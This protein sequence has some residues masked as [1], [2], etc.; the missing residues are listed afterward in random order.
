MDVQTQTALIGAAVTVFVICLACGGAIA[1]LR[2]A[3]SIRGLANPPAEPGVWGLMAYATFVASF[4]GSVGGRLLSFGPDA[5]IML[6]L[7][8]LPLV[9]I[10]CLRGLGRLGLVARVSRRANRGDLAGAIA[11]LQAAIDRRTP[12]PAPLVAAAGPFDPWAPPAAGPTRDPR[13]AARFNLMGILQARR[14][15]WPAALGWFERAD[16]TGGGEPTYQ[17]NRG[18]AL[19]ML[20]RPYEGLPL[21]LTAIGVVPPGDPFKRVA[22]GLSLAR[23]LLDAGHRG[24]ASFVLDQAEADLRAA[25]LLKGSVRADLERE[26]AAVRGRLAALPAE[27]GGVPG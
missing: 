24:K 5:L 4:A 2:W 26:I 3:R 23:T 13:A 14:D 20:G 22:L 9:A 11:E 10:G 27:G 17:L 1:L 7:S 21:A 8:A 16:A 19:V 18:E 15:D 12:R 25:D 6:V